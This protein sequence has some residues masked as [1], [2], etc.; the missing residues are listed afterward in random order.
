MEP[1]FTS[2]KVVVTQDYTNELIDHIIH[3]L[4]IAFG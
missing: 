4:M 2:T 1:P 3:A